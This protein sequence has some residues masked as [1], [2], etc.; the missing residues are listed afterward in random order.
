V[1]PYPQ[2]LLILQRTASERLPPR[3]NTFLDTLLL[4]PQHMSQKKRPTPALLRAL[5]HPANLSRPVASLFV[6]KFLH[7]RRVQNAAAGSWCEQRCCICEDYSSQ[8]EEGFGSPYKSNR[9]TLRELSPSLYTT[10]MHKHKIRAHL[11]AYHSLTSIHHI[12][13]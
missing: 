6:C 12:G 2:V 9:T 8:P 4:A 7:K 13:N 3:F 10:F 5:L 11:L 1:Y